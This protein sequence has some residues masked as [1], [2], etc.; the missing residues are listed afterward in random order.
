MRHK[1]NPEVKAKWLTALRSDKY[2]QTTAGHLCDNAGF[3]CL[4]V[5]TDLFI[6]EQPT[7]AEQWD[8]LELA[9]VGIK[10]YQGY[11]SQIPHDVAKWSGLPEGPNNEVNNHLMKRNDEGM[12]F[13][14]IATYIEE[15]L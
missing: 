15:N 13:K 1:M 10:T 11:G 2:K 6:K 8:D 12:P 4:G 14:D 9:G 3:C 5:L 7:D